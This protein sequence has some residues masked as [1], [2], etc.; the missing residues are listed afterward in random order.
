MGAGAGL[1]LRE[2]MADVRL[3]GLLREEEAVADLATH[4]AVRD[5]LKHLDL[6]G[7]RLLLQLLERAREGNDLCVAAARAPGRDGVEPPR[8]ADVTAQ[9]LLALRSVHGPT[10]GRPR[11]RL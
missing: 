6:A 3:D 2:Q 4:E 9:D 8:M 7:G 5:Q 10:I 11:L 1:Q